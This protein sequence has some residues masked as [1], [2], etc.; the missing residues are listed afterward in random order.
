MTNRN[1]GRIAFV[2]LGTAA[3]GTAY[4]WGDAAVAAWTARNAK[5]VFV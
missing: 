5:P 3:A 1:L 2:M 4:A